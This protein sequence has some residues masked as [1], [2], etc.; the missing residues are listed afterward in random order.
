[1]SGA[2]GPAR[3]NWEGSPMRS[4][5]VGGLGLALGWIATCFAGGT[6]DPAEPSGP[7]A[8]SMRR[9]V[10]CWAATLQP[11]PDSTA[12][13]DPQPDRAPLASHRLA[14]LGFR[15]QSADDSP[16]LFR[17]ATSGGTAVNELVSTAFA[18]DNPDAGKQPGANP[19]SPPKS[20]NQLADA[21]L[22]LAHKKPELTP[23]PP[24]DVA[25]HAP[26]APAGSFYG[27]AEFL[28]WWI[29]SSGTP[30]LVTSGG[31]NAVAPGS[32]GSPGTAILFG[33]RAIDHEEFSGARLTAGYW[34]DCCQSL[35]LES[36]YFFLGQR[37]VHFSANSNTF[38]IL[39][40]PFFN[41]NTGMEFR[42]ELAR[43]G[44]ATGTITVDL[45]S[46]LWGAELNARCSLCCGSD[47]CG[48]HYRV[49][50]IGGLR[51]L[52]LQEGLTVVENA[53]SQQNV[54]GLLVFAGDNLILHDIFGTRDRFY[55]LQLGTITEFRQGRWSLDFTGKLALGVTE[56]VID[57]NGN[58]VIPTGVPRFFNGGLLAL[59]SNIGH[60][61]R[62][63]FSVVGE[64][65]V[66]AGYQICDRVKATVGYTFLGWGDVVRPGDQIDR[67]LDVTMIPNF[68]PAGTVVPR[69]SG[70]VRPQ[71]PFR[72]TGFWAQGVNLGLEFCY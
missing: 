37:A 21:A 55:G 57:I 43:P 12:D 4:V 10:P 69:I 34:L 11:P 38:P 62:N 8:V 33:G 5:W 44:V 49:G 47:C 52:D 13:H 58:L 59:P 17:P 41:L 27:S 20:V 64:V 40:R 7:A 46:R 56:Q 2:C 66:R 53:V 45:P 60:R 26:R 1:M 71:V 31:V 68:V 24:P 19:E 18:V 22:A 42:E 28:T 61:E 32:L 36:T 9:P 72:E 30:P 63:R 23:T 3:K 16:V 6:A 48:F 54:P 65:G 25:E 35:G 70:M 51:Y 67:V 14:R 29:K 50:L 15:A 39:A